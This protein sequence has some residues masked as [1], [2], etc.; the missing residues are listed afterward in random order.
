MVAFTGLAPALPLRPRRVVAATRRPAGPAVRRRWMVAAAGGPYGTPSTNLSDPIAVVRLGTT[1]AVPQDATPVVPLTVPVV[2]VVAPIP[3]EP[4]PTPVMEPLGT[5][6][7][8]DKRVVVVGAG[9]AGLGAAHALVKAGHDVTLVDAADSVGGLVAGWRT[10]K[11]NKPVEVG[12]HG[13]WRPYENIFSLVK[14]LGI[15]DAFTPWTKSA[16]WSP[17]GLETESPIFAEQPRLPTPLGTLVYTKF[18]RLPLAH[19]LTAL[20]LLGVVADFDPRRLEDWKRYD[21]MTARELFANHGVSER[22]Y[23]EAFEPM[24]LVGLF[25]PGEECSAAAAMGMLLYFILN[26]QGDFD[27]VWGRGTVGARIF[28]PLVQSIEAGGGKVRCATRVKDV[29]TEGGRATGVVVTDK[30]GGGE[31]TL[32]ADAVVFAVGISGMQGI[33]RGSQT[34]GSRK[35]FAAVSN[36]GAVDVL[37]VRLYL[38]RKVNIGAASNAAFGFDNTTGWTFFDL[39]RL[40]DEHANEPTTV[41]E[42]DFYHANQLLV[43]SDED[44]VAKVQ[45]DI[46]ACVP[47]VR[48]ANVVDYSVVRV[49]RGVT[50]FRPGS[51]QHFLQTRTSIPNVFASGDWIVTEHGSFSQEKALVTGYEAAIAVMDELG[52]APGGVGHPTII[53]CGGG[54]AARCG[55]EEGRARRPGGARRGAAQGLAVARACALFLVAAGAA[56]RVVWEGRCGRRDASPVCHGGGWARGAPVSVLPDFVPTF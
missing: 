18:A 14:E 3:A 42:A 32:P 20:P 45:A 26:H 50:H 28:N 16:Q 49:P 17:A 22:L 48:D 40:H 21:N 30:S 11:G 44:I 24:L 41:L 13:F 43:M 33:V 27:V 15:T 31:E 29:E 53:P 52:T 1:P 19:R 46:G 37:A 8:A 34:L 55:G 7:A 54:R 4:F 35:E 10:A 9:W 12:I 56:A 5:P 47:A 36:L 25:A 38:D 39:N 51:F 2:P 23:K 6:V